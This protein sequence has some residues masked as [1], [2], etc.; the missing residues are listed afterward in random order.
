MA[1]EEL[2]RLFASSAYEPEPDEVL[3]REGFANLWRGLEAVGGHLYLTSSRLVFRSHAVNIQTGMWVW[4]LASVTSLEPV[5]SLRV[6]PN[7]L[8]L[9]LSDGDR[10]RLVVNRRRAWIDAI[11]RART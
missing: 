11:Q 6:I 1:D 8:E 3:V 7:G 2:L 5:N 10:V 4:P 9:A